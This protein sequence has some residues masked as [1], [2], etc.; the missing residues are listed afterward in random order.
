[1]RRNWK[2][3]EKVFALN[4][5]KLDSKRP[6]SSLDKAVLS[7][8]ENKTR[9]IPKTY[10]SPSGLIEKSKKTKRVK[11]Y[12]MDKEQT[13]SKSDKRGKHLKSKSQSNFAPEHAIEHKINKSK[14]SKIK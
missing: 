11:V 5:K 1:M 6:K 14:H 7:Q 13:I 9:K 12:K 10:Q 4:S 2:H 3:I 8:K